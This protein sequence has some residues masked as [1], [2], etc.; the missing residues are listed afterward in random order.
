MGMRVCSVAGCPAIYEDTESRCSSC[1]SVARAKRTDNAV[2]SSRGH[3]AFRAAVLER[4]PI[5]VICNAAEATVADHYPMGRRE[6]VEYGAD[7]NDPDYGRGL[8]HR[9]HSTETANNP[10]QRGGWNRR[11]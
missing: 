9:C 10:E 11:D 5:C 2:Y 6:L 3:R 1:K 8:C 7:P 4:D